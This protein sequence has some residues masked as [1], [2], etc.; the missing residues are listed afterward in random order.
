MTNE[1]INIV[2]VKLFS[3][4]SINWYPLKLVEEL[5]VKEYASLTK[6]IHNENMFD[7]DDKEKQGVTNANKIMDNNSNSYKN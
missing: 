1:Y 5:W 2:K 4:L 3:I 6:D 7:I